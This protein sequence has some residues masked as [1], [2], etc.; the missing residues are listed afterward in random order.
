MEY[1][2]SQAAPISVK[3]QDL[4]SKY[5]SKCKNLLEEKNDLEKTMNE[6][7]QEMAGK[8]LVLEVNNEKLKKELKNKNKS[9]DQINKLKDQITKVNNYNFYFSKILYDIEAQLLETL[10]GFYIG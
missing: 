7:K 2:D 9:S 4:I 10:S 6:N 5:I 1:M 3:T 8:I